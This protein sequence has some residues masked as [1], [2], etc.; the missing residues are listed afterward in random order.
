[1]QYDNK[2]VYFKKYCPTCKYEEVPEEDDPCNECL[3]YPVN[4]HTDRPV[5]WEEKEK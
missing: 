1:M 5:K 4:V 3:S 2:M